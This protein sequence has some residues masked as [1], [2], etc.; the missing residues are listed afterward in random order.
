[1][2]LQVVGFLQFAQE[3]RNRDSPGR[4]AGGIGGGQE[5]HSRAMVLLGLGLPDVLQQ[6]AS[7]EPAHITLMATYLLVSCH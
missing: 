3:A 2:L 5:R 6:L 4:T 1:M 7:L